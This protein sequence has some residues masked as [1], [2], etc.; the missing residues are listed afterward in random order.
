MA[1]NVARKGAP[2]LRQYLKSM[3]Q[4][5]LR[6]ALTA[7]ENGRNVLHLCC[8][9]GLSSQVEA[10]LQMVW[11]DHVQ[12]M[13]VQT[14]AGDTALIL[15]IKSGH[16]GFQ[17]VIQTLLKHGALVETPGLDGLAPLH[18]ASVLGQDDTLEL[19]QTAD[20]DLNILTKDGKTALQLAIENG[21][22][23]AV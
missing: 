22:F 10:I 4:D 17:D 20:L 16:G 8:Q 3:G 14:D 21:Q 7:K 5:E 19:F 9:E 13:D 18:H 2:A 12:Y 11:F 15:A 1:L 23:N 6:E